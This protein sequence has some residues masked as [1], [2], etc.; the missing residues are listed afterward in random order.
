M[1]D[2]LRRGAVAQIQQDPPCYVIPSELLSAGRSSIT[3][4]AA[5]GGDKRRFNLKWLY[6]YQWLCF[7]V[8]SNAMFCTLCKK[9]KRANQFARRGSRNFKTSA[10][11]DHSSSNDHQ[12]SVEQFDSIDN[13]D[14]LA[15]MQKGSVWIA[16][17]KPLGAS[18]A[19]A[20][21]EQ[22]SAA[23]IPA[24]QPVKPSESSGSSDTSALADAAAPVSEPAQA[25]AGEDLSDV[26]L[27][28]PRTAAIATL[29]TTD[30][31]TT[32]ASRIT[33]VDDRGNESPRASQPPGQ[34]PQEQRPEQHELS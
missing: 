26:H 14:D 20:R 9:S 11:V 17:A 1:D 15:L 2:L 27:D 22:T 31:L 3:I 21:E 19:T 12:R 4:G 34:K 32:A 18:W 5:L 10:L 28:A 33:S 16:V 24:R 6:D 23:Q 25:A 8:L 13:G 7:D 30:T 29:S